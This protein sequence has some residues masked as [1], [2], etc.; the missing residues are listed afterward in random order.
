MA[1]TVLS[2]NT[3][4]DEDREERDRSVTRREFFFATAPE[5]VEE[6]VRDGNYRRAV[7]Y[8]YVSAAVIQRADAAAAYLTLRSEDCLKAKAGGQGIWRVADNIDV[9]LVCSTGE[10]GVCFLPFDHDYIA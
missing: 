7:L 6:A 4:P 3:I 1:I 5:G 10:P 8:C 2:A 9:L